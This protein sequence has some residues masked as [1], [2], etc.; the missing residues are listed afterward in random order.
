M[1]NKEKEP[2]LP[3]FIDIFAGCGGLS[4]GLFSSGWQG[5]FA[6]ER[7]EN[8]FSTLNA[9]LLSGDSSKY[10]FQWPQW[11]EKKPHG[12]ED[13]I[14]KHR[15]SLQSLAGTIDMIVGG[16]PCQGFSS[17]G[18]RDPN[19]PRNKLTEA[20]LQF[21]SIVQ[22]KIVLIENVKGI[23]VDFADDS[24]EDGKVNYAKWIIET[25]SKNY[26]VYTKLIDTST[27]GVPQKR[28]RFFIVGVRKNLAIALTANPFDFIEG[29][30]ESFLANKG[31]VTPVSAISA[32][33]DLEIGKN[34]KRASKDTEGFEEISYLGPLTAYQKLMNAGVGL[35]ITDTRLA[36]HSLEI[37]TRFSKIIKICHDHGRLNISLSAELKASF[38]LKKCA[39]RVLDPDSPA[40]TITSMPDDLIH[41]RE[42]RT[43]TVR[44]NAR[45]QSCV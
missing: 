7:D 12:I 5:I 32:I 4:S 30:R 41:Y 20:Y 14:E 45:L 11:L 29:M 24:S 2:Q 13:F 43:L 16:P 44:E 25:L 34:G 15:D 17:A 9:N 37:S 23:T 3:T 22:P 36:R 35:N 18:R 8:A 28:S 1:N 42:A 39:I 38:G 33:S 21:V 19:D 26:T 6:V 31:L 40:P 10:N 27:F